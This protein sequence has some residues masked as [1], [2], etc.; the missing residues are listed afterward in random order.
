MFTGINAIDFA[1]KFTCNEDC[2]NYL[3]DLKWGNGFR[4]FPLWMPQ[5]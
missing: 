1:K 5:L 3:I 4:L 2:Y